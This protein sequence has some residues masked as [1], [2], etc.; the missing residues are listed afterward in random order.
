MTPM[1]L[2]ADEQEPKRDT[3]ADNRPDALADIR[4]HPEPPCRCRSTPRLLKRVGDSVRAAGTLLNTAFRCDCHSKS[5]QSTFQRGAGGAC[6][7]FSTGALV[8]AMLKF[9]SDLMPGTFETCRFTRPTLR[10]PSGFPIYSGTVYL[11]QVSSPIVNS[12][13]CVKLRVT[14]KA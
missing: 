1:T 9:R 2:P 5:G 11:E 10:M 3:R 7:E 13:N 8:S 14:V 6:S 12:G 4:A